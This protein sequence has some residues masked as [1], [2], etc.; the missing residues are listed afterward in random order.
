MLLIRLF[1]GGRAVIETIIDD[2]PSVEDERAIQQGIV[3]FSDAHT[4]P[5]NYRPLRL[6]LRSGK[7]HLLGGLLGSFV[8]NWLQ[9]DTLWIDEGKRNRGYGSLLL[10]QAEDMAWEGGCRFARLET[11][12]FEARGFYEKHGYVVYGELVNFPNGHSQYHLMKSISGPT[13]PPS[14]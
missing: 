8:W 13:N 1:G 10:R 5:R 11:F 9:I 14:P 3:L 12:D 2:H 6:A 4:P 7:G